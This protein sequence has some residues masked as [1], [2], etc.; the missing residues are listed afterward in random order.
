MKQTPART[1][2]AALFWVSCVQF[3]VFEAISIHAAGPAYSLRADV[4]SDLGALGCRSQFC[5]PLHGW[6]NASFVV[7]GMLIACG[8]WFLRD[9]FPAGPLTA[10]AMWLLIAS[11]AGVIGVGLAP[12]DSAARA[13]HVPS[14]AVH[15]VGGILGMLLL[16]IAFL[17]AKKVWPAFLSLVAGSFA[18]I[19]FTLL[20]LDAGLFERCVAYPYTIWLVAMGAR[21]LAAGEV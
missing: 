13:W 3:F 4:I 14:A 7:Q 19:A 6:M 16:G 17:R 18:L 1:F 5:S 10:A 21:I 20:A 12:E 8:A 15:F 2:P 11:G 9:R